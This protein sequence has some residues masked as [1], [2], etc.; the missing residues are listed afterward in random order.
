MQPFKLIR[1]LFQVLKSQ[2]TP[3]QIAL[4][5][6]LGM[7]LGLTPLGRHG[8]LPVALAL[9]FRVSWGGMTLGFG[10][11]KLLYFP[12]R[13]LTYAAGYA[14]LEIWGG[15]DALWAEVFHWPLLAWT[16][17]NQYLVFGG[18]A[19]A[20]GASLVVFPVVAFGVRRYR[21]G[22]GSRL[23][24]QRL[25]WLGQTWYGKA[26]RW[27]TVGGEAQF[28]RAKPR[29]WPLRVLRWQ[30]LVALPL[31]G[32]L[33]YVAAAAIVP[34]FAA[35]LVT[36]PTGWVLGTQAEV[37]QA[38]FDPLSGRLSFSDFSVVDPKAPDEH[39]LVV[40]QVSLEVGLV[41]LME[42][43]VVIHQASAASI[44]LH[45]KREADGSLNL[46]NVGSGWDAAGYLDW[47]KTHAGQV[48]WWG[49]FEK[50]W[51]YWR[52]RPPA[53]APTPQPDFSGAHALE[54]A[55]PWFALER[56]G[57]ERFELTLTDSF[58]HGGPLP[59][60]RQAEFILENVV[61]PPRR[62]TRPI[63]VTLSG[64]LADAPGARL[65]LSLTFAPQG[66]DAFLTSLQFNL[67]H[68]ELTAFSP[69]YEHSLPVRVLGGTASLTGTL[70]VGAQGQLDGAVRWS[71]A[72]LKLARTAEHPSL[73][74][75]DPA[76]SEAVVQ[77]LN[78][79]SLDTPIA[80]AFTMGGTATTPTFDWEAAFLDVAVQGLE[81]QANVLLQPVI[82]W[83]KQRIDAL[84]GSASNTGAEQTVEAVKG[85]I[86]HLLGQP[87]Q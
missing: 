64:Q 86:Q 81:R 27:L 34:H 8:L 16:E 35:T 87:D 77:G 55:Q 3:A 20:L 30:A 29:A 13:A 37:V 44:L 7:G 75:F 47:L 36:A 31:L 70:T 23:R 4:G 24:S 26:V 14:V 73:F 39:L 12:A 67:E 57:A 61:L 79:F 83:I 51:N 45:V 58:G 11:F 21:A 71:L 46:D 85:L 50:L 63:R 68:I 1:K 74:G 6:C 38:R 18:Y 41:G 48:D 69:L 60:L 76:T 53:T 32:A 17:L 33:A 5:V 15:L 59:A 78:R 28:D 2:G 84:G 62:A 56:I 22:Y 80:F 43:R 66:Q 19:V 10:A 65:E 40:G 42:K 72:G 52:T 9:V 54:R 82:L 49:L 25:A